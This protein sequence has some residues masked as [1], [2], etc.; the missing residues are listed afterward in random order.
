VSS[1]VSVLAAV[2]RLYESVVTDPE[3]WNEQSFGDWADDA[4][5]DAADLSKGAIREVRRCL[6]AAQKL[7]AFWAERA[8]D[9][10]EDDWRSRVDVALGARAWRPALDL[11]MAGL[12]EDPSPELYAEVQLRFPVVHS[13]RWM[14]GIDYETWLAA[15]D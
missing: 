4:L 15:D 10:A 1:Y 7:R 9:A 2:D 12:A 3:S 11:A 8:P 14:E 6:R 5:H 13:D